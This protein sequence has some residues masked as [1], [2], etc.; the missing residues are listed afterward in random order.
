M[1]QNRTT[2]YS[3]NVPK[4]R[5]M[6]DS[7]LWL[8]ILMGVAALTIDFI[9]ERAGRAPTKEALLIDMAWSGILLLGELL[10]LFF[11]AGQFLW[12]A[13]GKETI[14]VSNDQLIVENNRRLVGKL[15]SASLAAINNTKE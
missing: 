10:A 13:I 15:R 4:G 1:D 12:N 8:L 2:I 9:I 11:A 6:F 5:F 3:S 14:S 7:T